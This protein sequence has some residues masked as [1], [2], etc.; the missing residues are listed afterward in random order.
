MAF[1]VVD[2]FTISSI[3][4]SRRIE[5]SANINKI[6]AGIIVHKISR[7]WFSS[8]VRAVFFEIVTTVSPYPTNEVTRTPIIIAKS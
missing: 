3:A 1:T 4:Y 7:R 6:I 2:G 5:G 8:A